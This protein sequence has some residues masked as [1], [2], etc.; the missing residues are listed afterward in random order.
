VSEAPVGSP[1]IRFALRVPACHRID[2]VA[3]FAARAEDAG[4]H[5]VWFPDSQ[6][7]LR[8]VFMA[9]ALAAARTER[10]G[11]G[12]AVTN[13]ETRDVTV[14]A[15]AVRTLQ[16]LAPGRTLVGIG[17]G[18]TSVRPLG[19]RSTPASRLER[20]IDVLRSLMRGEAVDLGGVSCRLEAAQGEAPVYM[21]ASGPRNL[22]L[23]G[24]IADGVM[25]LTGVGPGPLGSAL[26]Q[27]RSGASETGRDP[28]TVEMVVG[29]YTRVT[30]DAERDARLLKPLCVGIA[31]KGGQ[32]YLSEA[33]IELPDPGPIDDIYPD[34]MHA[35][36]WD[37]AMEVSDRYVTD[38]MALRFAQTFCLFGTADEIADRIEGARALGVDGFYLLDLAGNQA[39]PNELMESFSEA[40]LPR[41]L[42]V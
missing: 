16:E 7:L 37:L 30:D 23:A 19:I 31:Q 32:E 24:R 17:A 33:G 39:L 15:S 11:L 41:F 26:Q 28:A 22:A 20:S 6:L 3:E 42:D 1:P 10:I 4:F 40:V 21:A 34:V 8:E 12:T 36:D 29:A 5:R 27:V 35:E 38:D 25:L 14:L 9:M 18:N 13:V 2:E